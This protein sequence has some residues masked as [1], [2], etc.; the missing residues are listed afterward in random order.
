MRVLP[1]SK[2]KKYPI[3]KKNVELK[4]K[5]KILLLLKS[6]KKILGFPIQP[7]PKLNSIR[8]YPVKEIHIGL[9]VSEI[10]RYKQTDNQT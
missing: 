8:S 1:P 2:E 3:L 5:K 4:F 10:L 6:K 9:A 7:L